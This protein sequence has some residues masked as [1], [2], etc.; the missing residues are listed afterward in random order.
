MNKQIIRGRVPALVAIFQT[1][2]QRTLYVKLPEGGKLVVHED[3][4]IYVTRIHE[5]YVVK[6][7][8]AENTEE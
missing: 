6:T 5:Q 3:G 2:L 4:T 7:L 8:K 1:K